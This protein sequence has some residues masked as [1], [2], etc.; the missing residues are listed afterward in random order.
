MK[1]GL[2]G[3]DIK[4][5]LSKKMHEK[6]GDF[7]NLNIEYDI[8]DLKDLSSVT[9]ILESYDGLN[10]TIPYKEAIIP[11][12]DALD[13]SA[14]DVGAVNT[15]VS[16]DG[17][18]IGY[19]TD[20]IGFEQMIKRNIIPLKRALI[21]GSG[22]AAKAVCKVLE[23]F[24]IESF[25]TSRNKHAALKINNNYLSKLEAEEKIYEFAIV[26]NCT[27]VGIDSES[28]PLNINEFN[29][30]SYIVDLIYKPEK[31]PFLKMAEKSGATFSNG[32]EMLVYQGASAFSL[33]T[34]IDIS[35]NEIFAMLGILRSK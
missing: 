9:N 6:F 12:L 11:Y 23:S 31:T 10:V 2:I 4:Y 33:F 19:N 8:L 3:K 27:P 16:K 28:L 30:K 15:I 7:K 18:F 24:N 25:I 32:L 17:K 20:C 14:K 5:S 29:E 35:K 34:N 22:G 13:K 26:V 1:L 21:I